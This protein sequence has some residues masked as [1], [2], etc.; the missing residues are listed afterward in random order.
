MIINGLVVVDPECDKL[1][2]AP[3]ESVY[4]SD[5]SG[6][7]A[8]RQGEVNRIQINMERQRGI[9]DVKCAE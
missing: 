4:C 1:T 2:I 3:G 6:H 5:I 7:Y 8:I 9:S